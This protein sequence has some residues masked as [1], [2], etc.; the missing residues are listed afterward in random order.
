M[1]PP[2]VRV[3]DLA[4]CGAF[5]VRESYARMPAGSPGPI[6]L[7][8]TTDRGRWILFAIDPMGSASLAADG[9]EIETVA[10]TGGPP[11]TVAAGLPYPD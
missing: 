3:V 7:L 4:T 11:Q 8:G 10:A 9:L 2:S 1:R 6:E 5:S